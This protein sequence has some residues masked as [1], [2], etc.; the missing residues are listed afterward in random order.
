MIFFILLIF[1]FVD[2]WISTSSL[3]C[4]YGP[5]HFRNNYIYNKTGEFISCAEQVKI[6]NQVTTLHYAVLTIDGH[7]SHYYNNNSFFEEHENETYQIS[8]V[9]TLIKKNNEY[10][11]RIETPYNS[12]KERFVT[13]FD[14]TDKIRKIT[15]VRYST[16][17][18]IVIWLQRREFKNFYKGSFVTH[19]TS[20][21]S[22]VKSELNDPILPTMIPP[23]VLPTPPLH[24]DL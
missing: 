18:P 15:S 23:S 3:T 14:G 11:K 19:T 5:A 22:F 7:G 1:P 9:V 4:A 8:D 2:C 17:Y 10:I 13:Y 12:R 6:N 24:D 20:N 16:R 21:G